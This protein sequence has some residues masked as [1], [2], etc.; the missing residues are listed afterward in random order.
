MVSEKVCKTTVRQGDTEEII[1][2]TF[3]MSPSALNL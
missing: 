2:R 1:T 3:F